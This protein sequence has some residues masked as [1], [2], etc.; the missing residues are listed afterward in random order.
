MP[1]P[2]QPLLSLVPAELLVY[3]S[4]CPLPSD[5]CFRWW[6]LSFWC[7]R[8]Y[9]HSHWTQ[10]ST[11]VMKPHRLL[12][13]VLH[14][15]CVIVLVRLQACLHWSTHKTSQSHLWTPWCASP[16]LYSVAVWN[17]ALQHASM[18]MPRQLKVRASEE[19]PHIPCVRVEF[20]VCMCLCVHKGR[21]RPGA[22][23]QP[24]F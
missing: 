2:I 17:P 13:F 14:A 7:M 18:P 24:C 5:P 4:I 22:C 6:L 15:A 10:H 19:R 23:L 3:E 9:A 1:P 20:E 16:L 12:R 8:A 11:A 21:C